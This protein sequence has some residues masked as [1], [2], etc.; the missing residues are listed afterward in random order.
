MRAIRSVPII[1]RAVALAVLGSALAIAPAAAAGPE[2][3]PNGASTIVW[4]AGVLCP[5][6]VEWDI[7][8]VGSTLIFPVKANGD[9]LIRQI[10]PMLTTVT[11]LESGASID[12]RGGIKLD[13]IF[14]AD[15]SIDANISGAVLAGYFPTDLGGPSMW[16]YRGHLHD[17]L[18][19]D[20][21]V[22]GHSFSG[23]ATD[24]CAALT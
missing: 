22:L 3:V 11:N 15:G 12:L 7:P 2:K 8:A 6:E 20:F 1:R 23:H 19:A 5:F 4:D 9:Q 24:L 21:T 17:V 14:H 16:F 10:G 18:T 13:L